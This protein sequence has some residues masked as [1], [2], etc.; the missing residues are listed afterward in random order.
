MIKRLFFNGIDMNG[1]RTAIDQA[2]QNTV[3]IDPCPAPTPL[4]VFQHARLGA[5]Q[6]LYDRLLL[7]VLLIGQK[8]Y[9]RRIW[10]VA[11]Q[12]IG[13]F[14]NRSGPVPGIGRVIRSG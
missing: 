10:G 5:Q 2:F 7:V 14:T 3:L 6:A 4:P 11:C 12:A 8:T 13:L 9:W 1:R